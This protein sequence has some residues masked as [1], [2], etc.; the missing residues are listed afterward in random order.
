[1]FLNYVKELNRNWEIYSS[2]SMRKNVFLNGLGIKNPLNVNFLIDLMGFG[3]F[4]YCMS[5][6]DRDKARCGL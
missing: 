6:P 3:I 5:V 2:R 1:M 4:N